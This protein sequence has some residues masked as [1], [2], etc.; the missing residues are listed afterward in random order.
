MHRRRLLKF[1][2]A[3]LLG[4]SSS[5]SLSAANANEI[6]QSQR[7]RI[8]VI[9]AGMA[10][11]AAAKMLHYQGHDVRI[12]EA[13]NRIGGRIWTSTQ[14]PDAPLDL[15][16][17]WIHGVRNNP[18]T[19]LADEVQ[20][21]R[22][23]TRYDSA[24]TYNTDG[25]ALSSAEHDRLD[26]LKKQV[27]KTLKQ[28]QN[29]DDDVSIREA[30]E[31]LLQGLDRS[32][33]RYRWI[34]FILNGTIEQEYSGSAANLSAYWYDKGRE[35]GGGDVLFA[36][37]FSA[38]TESL[39]SGLQIE[40][41]QQVQRIE[42]GRSPVRV[43]TQRSEFV[44]DRVVV[45][46]PL[47]VLKAQAVQFLPELPQPK[48]ESIAKL[49]M[50]VLNKCYLRFP[51]AF[52]PEDVDWLEYIPANHGEWTEWVNFTRVADQPILLGFNAADQGRAIEA[53]SD[54]QIVAS[55][56]ETLRTLFGADIPEPIEAQMTRWASDPFALG[57]Y[58][59]HAV[60]STPNMRRVLAAP[61]D[62][63]LFFAGEASHGTFSGTAHGAY[64]SGLRAA[65]QILAI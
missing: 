45:T 37:G 21:R 3:F 47:G 35:L 38:I 51:R 2:S 16:A 57:S 48:Q 56:M 42:W 39:A 8:L 10:G 36:Q 24:M 64:L 65:R 29:G 62:Q 5:R 52:W 28:A 40:L 33:E 61:L 53:W 30:I 17:S 44:A 25:R 14:W 15:G 32:S 27:L 60:G 63:A 1:I 50:G 19:D 13:R 12:I 22:V 31:P 23:I 6:E 34:N 54:A 49:G 11:L 43:I 18:L 46:L 9:G 59:Y 4:Y 55:A 7:Q 20:A 41:D 58:S 26:Q